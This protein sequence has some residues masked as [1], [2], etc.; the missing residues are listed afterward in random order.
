MPGSISEDQARIV[1][2]GLAGMLWSKQYYSFEA[3]TWLE[4]HNCHPLLGQ[5]G[6]ARNRDWYHMLNDDVISMPDKWEYPGTQRGTWLFTAWR[7][8]PSI[9]T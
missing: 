6:Q 9:A 8:R 7:C 3:D 4:E 2:Q 1:R 5:G